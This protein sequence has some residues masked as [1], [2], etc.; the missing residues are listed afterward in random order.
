[1]S[2]PPVC[3]CVPPVCL[4]PLQPACVSLCPARVSVSLTT[5]LCVFVSRQCVCL[6]CIP[7]H[8]SPARLRLSPIRLCVCVPPVVC[9]RVSPSTAL[10]VPTTRAPPHPPPVCARAAMHGPGGLARSAFLLG[11][12]LSSRVLSAVSALRSPPQPLDLDGSVSPALHSARWPCCTLSAAPLGPLS[13][14]L[15]PSP[16]ESLHP[17]PPPSP[18]P[19]TPPLASSVADGPA[20][21]AG[22]DA[23]GDEAGLQKDGARAAAGVEEGTLRPPSRQLQQRRRQRLLRAAGGTSGPVGGWGEGARAR[24]SGHE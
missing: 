20:T 21:E 11:R 12:A 3:L 19:G 22:G 8:L 6:P 9:P 15:V 5:R 16:Y 14:R 1:M 18:A 17:S 23:A 10:H 13:L 7:P 4:S 2:I 24:A